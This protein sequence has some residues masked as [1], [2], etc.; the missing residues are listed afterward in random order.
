MLIKTVSNKNEAGLHGQ[1]S[2][3]GSYVNSQSYYLPGT[4][5]RIKQRFQELAKPHMT[6]LHLSFE[7]RSSYVT[8]VGFELCIPVWLQ[9]CNPPASAGIMSTV[10]PDTSPL[11]LSCLNRILLCGLWSPKDRG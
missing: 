6:S 3:G 7:T 5:R 2:F 11:F 8:K 10:K 1:V 4:A 9:T